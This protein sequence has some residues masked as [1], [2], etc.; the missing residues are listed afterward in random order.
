MTRLIM[1][2]LR[3]PEEIARI[4]LGYIPV[5]RLTRRHLGS[6]TFNDMWLPGARTNQ[7]WG[8]PL[9]TSL[10]VRHGIQV[11][12]SRNVRNGYEDRND[13]QDGPMFTFANMPT[14]WLN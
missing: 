7:L 2:I 8:A 4:I 5:R 10:G 12:R 9:S 1:Q 13:R 14:T 3:V 11:A 6:I